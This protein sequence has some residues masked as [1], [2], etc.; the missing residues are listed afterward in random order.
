MNCV[1]CEHERKKKLEG[2]IIYDFAFKY[3]KNL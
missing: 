2:K 3:F 1:N